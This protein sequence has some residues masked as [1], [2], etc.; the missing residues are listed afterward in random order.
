MFINRE[1]AGRKLAA[2][3]MRFKDEDP[4]VLALPRGGVPVALEVAKALDAPLDLV[5]VR[6]IGA[7]FQPE[8]AIAAVVDGGKPELV[9]N[10]DIVA[11]LGIEDAFIAREE[12]RQLREIERRRQLYLAGR[13]RLNVEGKTAI[14]IDDGIAT[15]A[16]VRAAIYATRRANPK[17]IVVATP[18]APAETAEALRKEADEVVCLEEH[19]YFGGVGLYYLDFTQVTDDEVRD[20][21]TRPA[22]AARAKTA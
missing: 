3:L 12:A 6:K 17:R 18:V 8:L 20:M 13:D 15:G 4:C 9:I 11:E 19:R 5:L 21:M 7:P 1:D 2:V 10:E 22:P 14:I 16:T